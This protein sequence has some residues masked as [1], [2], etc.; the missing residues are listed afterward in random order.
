MKNLTINR[1]RWGTGSEGKALLNV[2]SNKMC[3]LGFV[4]RA[5]G[6]KANEIRGESMPSEICNFDKLST[7]ASRLLPFINVQRRND[8]SI[9]HQLASVNDSET[10]Y[11]NP[12][13]REARITALMAKLGIRVNFVN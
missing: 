13:K 2:E 11:K 9:T 3:C 10:T 5:A 12:A 1:K 7:R 6:F 4:C 8:R